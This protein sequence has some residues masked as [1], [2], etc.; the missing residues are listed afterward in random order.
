MNPIKAGDKV[1]IISPPDCPYPHETAVVQSVE[2]G[3]FASVLFPFDS[4]YHVFHVDM[5]KVVQE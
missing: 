3:Q 4:E 1:K 2:Y 5:L